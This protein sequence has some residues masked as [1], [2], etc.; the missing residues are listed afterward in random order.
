MPATLIAALSFEFEKCVLLIVDMQR[1]F[2]EPGGFGES[3]G[4][5]VSLIRSA[6]EP[7]RSLLSKWR[8]NGG[9]LIHTR[10][11]HKPDLSDL[12]ESKRTRG[13]PTVAI[14]DTGPMG[15]ILVRG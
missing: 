4:N 8:A 1:D 6:I 7:T 5:N 12:H 2:V 9:T 13:N 14:G 3:V 15:R 10:E 11:G